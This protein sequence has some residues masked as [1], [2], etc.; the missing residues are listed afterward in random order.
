MPA[1]GF[2]PEKR[3]AC[4]GKPRDQVLSASAGR[5]WSVL[6]CL[7][8]MVGL[9]RMGGHCFCQPGVEKTF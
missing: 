1:R 6:G 4:G 5:M 9:C 3:A 2:F 8:R 7:V